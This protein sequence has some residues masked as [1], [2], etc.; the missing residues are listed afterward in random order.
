[1]IQSALRPIDLY[2]RVDKNIG[3]P[4]G[5]NYASQ[6]GFAP[7]ILFTSADVLL[8]PGAIATLVREMDNPEAGIAA[9][10]LLFPEVNSPHGPPGSIQSAGTA[11][12]I[13]GRPYHIFIAWR[14]DNPRVNIR[15]DSMSAVT[16]ACF[17]TRRSLWKEIGGFFEGYGKGTFEDMEYCFAVRRR[18]AK[19]IYTPL[20]VGYHLVNGSRLNGAGEGFALS[21]NEQLFRM[22][23]RDLLAWDEWRFW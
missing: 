12:N 10:K 6:R 13:K 20:A 3:Y 16:G 19:V 2:L 9:P 4:G 21:D 7:L 8:K 11:F 5:M 23:N 15:R 17:I 1:M 18:G 14:P 22:R